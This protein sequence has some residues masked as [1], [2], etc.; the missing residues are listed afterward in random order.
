M[1][2]L[3]L[4]WKSLILSGQ[5]YWYIV[6][7]WIQNIS[8]KRRATLL[9]GV[10]S[11]ALRKLD[12]AIP[13]PEDCQYILQGATPPLPRKS[14][15][16]KRRLWNIAFKTAILLKIQ[17]Q[18]SCVFCQRYTKRKRD[19]RNSYKKIVSFFIWFP[20]STKALESLSFIMKTM[21]GV[22]LPE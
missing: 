3:R 22:I 10:R 7:S 12:T 20:Q 5:E 18:R 2:P 21:N 16:R 14:N 13:P 17:I 6:P 4:T 11:W 8:R 15:F 19:W 1:K 9:A